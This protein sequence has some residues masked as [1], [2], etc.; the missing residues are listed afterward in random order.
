MA[1]EDKKFYKRVFKFEVLSE[2]PLT[3]DPDLSDL[4]A[5]TDTGDC[6][7]RFLEDDGNETLTGAQ[8]AKALYEAGSE[9]GFFQLDDDGNIDEDEDDEETGEADEDEAEEGA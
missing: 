4:D 1:S 7:G 3:G 6:V 8:M 9:P 5:M 2:E